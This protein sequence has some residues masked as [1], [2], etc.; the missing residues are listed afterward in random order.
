MW[1]ETIEPEEA[2]GRLA[3]LYDRVTGPSGHVDRILAAHSL[4]PRT[5]EGH[6]ALYKSVLHTPDIALSP[7]EREL[8]GVVVSHDNQ[9]AYCVTHHTAGLARHL[10]GDA[11]AAAALVT[12]ALTRNAP[13]G[14]GVT[15][16]ERAMV[17]YARKLTRAPSTMT[18][19][20]LAPLRAAGL[21][22]GAILDLNQVAAYFAYANRTVLGLG[23]T[24]EGERLGLHPSDGEDDLSHS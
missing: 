11:E 15:E 4:R 20:D 21:D 22:D 3:K 5:M 19:E 1:I 18:V 24:T 13:V 6:L 2:E 9:C 12:A 23:V 10:G 16:R 7:R 17:G 8:V 14:D